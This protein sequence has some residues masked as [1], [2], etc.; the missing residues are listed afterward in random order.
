MTSAVSSYRQKHGSDQYLLATASTP[1]YVVGAGLIPNTV[2]SG[3]TTEV[4]VDS[5]GATAA[6]ATPSSFPV[7]TLFRD[8]GRELY[9]Y[10]STAN[11]AGIDSPFQKL[12]V[13]REV[14]PVTAGEAAA[15]QSVWVKVWSN[16]G[17][18]VT[19]ARTG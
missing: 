13:W 8:V 7:G 12:A 2:V 5:T 11:R 17:T 1:A 4:M 3:V 16:S 14:L 6:A 19:V 18:A 15:V 10:S 9:L